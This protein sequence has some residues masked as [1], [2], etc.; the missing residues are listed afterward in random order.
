MKIENII[1]YGTPI[2]GVMLVAV[3]G[4]IFTNTGLDWLDT[5]N[6]PNMWLKVYIIPT[7][8]SIIYTLFSTYLIYLT[9]KNQCNK[10]LIALL[11]LNGLIN[12]VWCLVYFYV[13]NILLGLIIIIINLIL[14]ILL[15]IEIYKRNLKWSYVLMIYPTWLSIATCL[16]LSIWILN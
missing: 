2:L 9:Y 12:V 3:L 8:W 4:T 14:S 13:K 16:N 1:K 15:L 6:K 10:K 5:L 11:I 7:I